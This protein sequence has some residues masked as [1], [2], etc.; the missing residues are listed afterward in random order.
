MRTTEQIKTAIQNIKKTSGILSILKVA[1]VGEKQ[2]NNIKAVLEYCL[3]VMTTNPATAEQ[4]LTAEMSAL[5]S[6]ADG[7][8]DGHRTAENGFKAISFVLGKR[9]L[10]Y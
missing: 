8:N 2:Q 5:K 7:E 9:E 4:Q 1:E 3:N 10:P 6:V